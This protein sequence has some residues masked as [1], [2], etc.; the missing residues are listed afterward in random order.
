MKKICPLVLSQAVLKLGTGHNQLKFGIFWVTKVKF[1][2]NTKITVMNEC[3]FSFSFNCSRYNTVWILISLPVFL[4]LSKFSV[5]SLNTSRTC[6]TINDGSPGLGSEPGG[7]VEAVAQISPH[8]EITI[9]K[10]L[11]VST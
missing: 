7:R 6:E 8:F 10:I 3:I 2:G 4:L 11:E 5:T 1:K 9:A